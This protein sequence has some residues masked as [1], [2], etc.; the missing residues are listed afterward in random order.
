MR[1]EAYNQVAQLYNK[2][3]NAESAEHK[4]DEHRTR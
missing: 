1:V 4:A 2:R 3:E